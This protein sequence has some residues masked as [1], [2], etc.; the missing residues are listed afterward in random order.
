MPTAEEV[1]SIW[2]TQTS[3]AQQHNGST[4]LHS[5]ATT[6][7]PS[8]L[9]ALGFLRANARHKLRQDHW[10]TETE[11]FLLKLKL[12]L[13]AN[14]ASHT[15]RDCLPLH[16]YSYLDEFMHF[17]TQR[18]LATKSSKAN[19]NMLM[20]EIDSDWSKSREHS[21]AFEFGTQQSCPVQLRRCHLQLNHSVY[22]MFQHC[23]YCW[24]HRPSACEGISRT[25]LSAK[26][27]A[28]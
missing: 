1:I 8:M 22:C 3:P 27:F 6:V 2:D 23:W 25:C 24:Y 14:N 21:V 20:I 16:N 11:P 7:C 28:W 19:G 5:A 17:W 12:C 18:V 15:K 10:A 9:L 26:W 4:H 13:A